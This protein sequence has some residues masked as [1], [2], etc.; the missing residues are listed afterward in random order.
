MKWHCLYHVDLDPPSLAPL[1]RLDFLEVIAAPIVMVPMDA[2]AQNGLCLAWTRYAISGRS[3]QLFV[4]GA[5]S[6]CDL[7]LK[8][9]NLLTWINRTGLKSA[10]MSRL[11]YRIAPIRATENGLCVKELSIFLQVNST[12]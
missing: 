11:N 7:Y 6:I 9:H 4:F 2:D 1:R 8:P 3:D 12:R 10:K 5:T